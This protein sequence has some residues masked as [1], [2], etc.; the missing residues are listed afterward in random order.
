VKWLL[1]HGANLNHEVNGV[2]DCRVLDAA[3]VNSHLEIV[4]LLVESGAAINGAHPEHNALSLAMTHGNDQIVQYLRSKGAMTPWELRGEP[5]PRPP[6]REAGSI[7]G[8]VEYHLGSVEPLSLQEIVSGSPPITIHVVRSE[9]E[10]VLVTDGMSSLPMTVPEGSEKFQFAE[11]VMRLPAGWP[12]DSESLN[13]PENLWP[14]EWLRRIARHP[15][16]NKTWLGGQTFVFRNG[17][18]PAPFAPN[19]KLSCL[20]GIAPDNALGEYGRSDGTV[21]LFYSL[22]PIYAEEA[23]LE[24]RKGVGHLLNLFMKHEILPQCDLRRL[25]VALKSSRADE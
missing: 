3:A 17:E 14:I 6:S 20:L 2:L 22:Y 19:T 11:L 13:W 12:L 15:H 1:E 23:E 24:K 21:V 9:D 10:I 8:Y 5:P 18:P 7:L 4:K 25:N 16:E